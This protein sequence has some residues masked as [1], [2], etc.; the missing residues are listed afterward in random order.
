MQVFPAAFRFVA[1][2]F[3]SVA[4]ARAGLLKNLPGGGE[5]KKSGYTIKVSGG[6]EGDQ[7]VHYDENG[8]RSDGPA[9][10]VPAPEKSRAETKT[11]TPRE[12]PAR[13]GRTVVAKTEP[14]KPAA[15]VPGPAVA[16]GSVPDEKDVSEKPNE[17]V[18]PVVG[19]Y[20]GKE[21]N[22][23]ERGYE[24]KDAAVF[25]KDETFDK[26]DKLTYGRW[27]REDEKSSDRETFAAFGTSDKFDTGEAREK[28]FLTF[29]KR[30]GA[31]REM[32][33][34]GDERAEVASWTERFSSFR[35]GR[36]VD[37]G[38]GSALRDRMANGYT[39]LM[40]VSMQDI[41]KTAFR[42]NHSSEKGDLP[43]GK[44]G[45]GPGAVSPLSKPKS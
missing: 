22:L 31:D 4:V 29:E 8:K 14:A 13:T 37:D 38:S 16:A 25:G 32:F 24:R 34:R 43:V 44:V 28:N 19:R 35:N 20:T 9:P 41:G 6:E 26:G 7:E 42:R 3:A 23:A 1:I 36:F 10:A 2:V 39:T 27:G 33:G 12:T 21:H 15:A 17:T 11:E 18:D 5:V 45:A 30:G 40:Q